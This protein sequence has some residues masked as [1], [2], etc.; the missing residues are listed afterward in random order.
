[1]RDLKKFLGLIVGVF[2]IFGQAN[3]AKA[4]T[5][6]F[7]EP[8]VNL[9]DTDPTISGVS[10]WAGDPSAGNDT[11]VDDFWSSGNPYLASGFD[12]GT[13][14]SP[15]LYDTFIGASATGLPFATVTVD[16]LSE[17][18]LPGGTTLYLQAVSTGTVV[19]T[20]SVAVSGNQ[21]YSLTVSNGGGFDTVYIY[22]DLDASGFGEA[23]HIDNFDFTPISQAPIPEPGTILLIA[24]GLAGFAFA[25]GK[26]KL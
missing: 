7:S 12:D 11:Y 26:K 5:I 3:L 25:R 24:S 16:I 14:N 19:D 6:T 20:D 9:G 10:F 18:F 1:M 15:G 2:L 4:T 22:D 21:Y 13:G 8:G 17:L 23:F